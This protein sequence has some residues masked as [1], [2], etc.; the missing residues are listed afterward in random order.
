MYSQ[1]RPK[2]PTRREDWRVLFRASCMV[3]G[4]PGY[5]LEA[6]LV[7]GTSLSLFIFSRNVP[8]L[9]DVI[10]FGTLPP[11]AKLRIVAGMYTGMITVSR[12]LTSVVLF[13]VAA[14]FGLNIALLT[15]YLREY[16]LSLRS[17]SG[18]LGGIVLGTLGAGCA[19]CGSAVIAGVLSMVGGAGAATFLPL[20]GLEFALFA[21]PLIFLSTY[22][23]AQGMQREFD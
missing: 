12:P 16:D 21:I 2:L 1:V 9:V 18:S 20:D 17:G 11:E 19:S 7:T 15:Y 13:S 23:L 6:A 5:A 3:L 10:L 14:L 4:R 8:L 22:W